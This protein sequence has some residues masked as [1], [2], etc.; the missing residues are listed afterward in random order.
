MTFPIRGFGA[1][2]RIW[3]S[4]LV[5]NIIRTWSALLAVLIAF[6]C[7]GSTSPP[8]GRSETTPAAVSAVN[9]SLTASSIQAGRT[10]QATFSAVD[11]AGRPLS[12]RVANW[13]SSDTAIA[14]VSQTGLVTGVA[15]G[16]ASITAE[17]EGKRSSAAVTVTPGLLVVTRAGTYTGTW[18][19][20]DADVPAVA[21]RTGAPVVIEHCT[22]RGKGDLIRADT[23][24]VHVTIRNCRGYGLEPGIAGKVRGSFFFSCGVGSLTL[25]NNYIEAVSIGATIWG[26]GR[27][28]TPDGP[29]LIRYN[30]VKNLDG[31]P[32]DGAGGRDISR[33]IPGGG[34]ISF[35]DHHAARTEIAWNEIVLEPFKSGVED[36]I[37]IGHSSGTPEGPIDIHDNFI[38]GGYGAD[39]TRAL[40][41]GGGITM[42]GAPGDL[43]TTATSFVTIH[44]NQFANKANFA[45]GLAAG[46]DVEAYANRVITSG[47]LPDGSWMPTYTGIY[48]QNGYHQP[49]N[50]YFNNFAHD[51]IVG[52]VTSWVDPSDVTKRLPPVRNDYLLTDCEGGLTAPPSKCVNNA[53]IPDPITAS[54][55]QSEFVLWQQKL[56][57]NR[58]IVGPK[59]EP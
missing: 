47:Y 29:I 13:S 48:I 36:V 32:S 57:A 49:T 39:P 50:V 46:H 52:W 41:Y 14:I 17:V 16:N 18:E 22:V 4:G 9:V 8:D 55:E 7:A 43:P 10:T 20:D 23:N 25:E 28:W 11:N 30:Q 53:S 33:Y 44:H 34:F 1:S 35:W 51:N 37:G 45:I 26:C 38:Q 3:T 59:S 31:A 21:I 24:Y 19:S 5:Q 40:Y 2:V 54:L 27:D 6:A 12:G 15:P 56:A 42:D 58:L